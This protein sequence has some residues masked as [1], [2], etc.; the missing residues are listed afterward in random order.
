MLPKPPYS[1]NYPAKLAARSTQRIGLVGVS[2]RAA[3]EALPA[4]LISL[5]VDAYCD[6]D[7]TQAIPDRCQTLTINAANLSAICAT[8]P[9]TYWMMSGGLDLEPECVAGLNQGP[10]RILGCSQDTIR[11]CKS[12]EQWTAGLE[13][14]NIATIPIQI[15]ATCPPGH[16][17]RKRNWPEASS[18]WFWQKHVAGTLGSA[19][20]LARPTGVELVGCSRLFALADWRYWGNVADQSWPDAATRC[21]LQRM[22]NVLASEAQLLGLFGIDFVLG[23]QLWPLEIN[24][25]PTASVEVLA[26]LLGRNLYFEHVVACWPDQQDISH[27]ANFQAENETDVPIHA[28]AKRIIYNSR[29]VLEITDDIF[30]RLR[31]LNQFQRVAEALEPFDAGA[32]FRLADLPVPGTRIPAFEPICSILFK[33]TT[34][35]DPR[36]PS[37]ELIWAYLEKVER[38]LFSVRR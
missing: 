1:N 36:E 9:N 31:Q 10:H 21:D 33:T 20:F 35:L 8:Q 11:Y 15:S 34:T 14:A 26:S 30:A 17:H 3:A 23:Q 16:W 18:S 5:A 19:I 13:R 38:V 24:P 22:A 29:E 12:Q 27:L 4:D 37:V 7:T 28:S 6:W 2:V 25:R 32:D